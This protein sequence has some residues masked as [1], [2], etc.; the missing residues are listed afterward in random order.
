[1]LTVLVPLQKAAALRQQ[2]R[3][4]TIAEQQRARE[5]QLTQAE[6]RAAA[7]HEER[8]VAGRALR[9][10]PMIRVSLRS[11]HHALGGC[12]Q[13]IML[14]TA[15]SGWRML[16]RRQRGSEMRKLLT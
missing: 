1:M 4:D 13:W 10:G 16:R 9:L 6:R 7:L 5:A 8:Q 15:G 3:Q 12:L 11:C 2:Q 14:H